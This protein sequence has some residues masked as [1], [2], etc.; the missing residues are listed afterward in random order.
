M[1]TNQSRLLAFDTS[2][3]YCAA[4]LMEGDL[5]RSQAFEPM[6]RGQAEALMPM[7]E[8]LLRS[9]GWTW[10]DLAGL[11]V[12]VGPGNFT[13]I[14]IGVSAARGLALGL[15]VPALPL[16]S[17]EL[18]RDPTGPAAHA[19]EVVLVPAPR[20]QAYVQKFRYGRPQNEPR[21]I[22][23]KKPPEDLRAPNLRVTGVFSDQVAARL[24]A[25]ETQ[26]EPALETL[27][28][29]LAKLAEWKWSTGLD[30]DTRP[31]PLYVRAADAAPPSDPPPVIVP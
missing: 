23:P 17:F 24:G 30:T 28:D 3:P 22:D 14:R 2:G 12:G 15:G 18:T 5:R 26:P 19:Q 10:Q 13:G 20:D 25:S 11:A 29:R 16:S 31:A 6:A 27:P 8:A 4:A 1:G 21:L 9:E 7:L